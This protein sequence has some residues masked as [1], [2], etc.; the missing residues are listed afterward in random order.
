MA[1]Q[2][3]AHDG[4][5]EKQQRKKRHEGVIGNEGSEEY[6]PV[7]GHLVYDAQWEPDPRVTAL[8]GVEPGGAARRGTHGYLYIRVSHR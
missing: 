7:V 8:E 5:E 6:R 2:D 3:E 1:L 4:D